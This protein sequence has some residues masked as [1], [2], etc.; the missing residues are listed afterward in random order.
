AEAG[1]EAVEVSSPDHTANYARHYGGMARRLGLLATGGSDW[2]GRADSDI[3]LG[4]GRGGLA[5]HCTVVE[6]MKARLA[7]RGGT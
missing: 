2:H 1:I 6:Q 7:A 3:R 5:V 4:V